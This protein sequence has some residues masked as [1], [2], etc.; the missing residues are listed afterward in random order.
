MVF[1]AFTNATNAANAAVSNTAAV[2]ANGR[3]GLRKAYW[4]LWFAV[5]MITGVLSGFLLSH[6]VM[7]GRYFTWLIESG[8]NQ[9]FG[10]TFSIFREATRANIHYNLFLWISFVLGIAWIPICFIARKT[11]VV[12]VIAGLSTL[13]VGC[14]FFVSNF[15]AAEEAVATGT[16][17]EAVRQFF[18]SWNLPMHA[19]FAAFYSICFFLLLLSGFR[20]VRRECRQAPV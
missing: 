19:S 17:T 5:A 4:A 7:L 9:V 14:V 8:N 3:V 15:A 10:D 12:A 11:R 13:W 1:I 20:E 2:S 18:V 6:S 16:A